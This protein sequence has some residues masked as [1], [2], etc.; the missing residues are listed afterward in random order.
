MPPTWIVIVLTVAAVITSTISGVIGM[1]GGATLLGIM[2]L[3][4]IDPTVV[5]PVHATIQL[6]SNGSRAL[7]LLRHVRWRPV[8]WLALPA[9]PGLVLGLLFLDLPWVSEDVI[10]FLMGVAILYAA[11]TPKWGLQNLSER[12]AFA[13]AGFVGGAFGVV[14]GAIGPLTAPFFL[15]E[16][17]PRHEVVATKAVCATYFHIVK[18]VAFVG[19]REFV[20]GDHLGLILPMAAATIVGTWIGKQILGKISETAFRRIYRGVLTLLALRILLLAVWA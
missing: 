1:G 4:G 2:I 17:Y 20:V 19:V 7:L 9:W 6:A 10:R 8:L 3:V 13:L 5:I 18:L 14:I 12:T 16:D 11:W 15:R